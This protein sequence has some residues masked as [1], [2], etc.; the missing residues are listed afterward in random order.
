MYEKSSPP[1]MKSI[2]RQSCPERRS[3]SRA[4]SKET[5]LVKDVDL[6]SCSECEVQLDDER[7]IY[8]LQN[9][10]FSFCCLDKPMFI[11]RFLHIDKSS[12]VFSLGKFAIE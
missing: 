10:T 4:D 6:I 1:L 5:L 3:H 8:H 9:T 12:K 2:T 7:M 11:C